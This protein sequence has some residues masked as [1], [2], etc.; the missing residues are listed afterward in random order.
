MAARP[1]VMVQDRDLLGKKVGRLRSQG[2]VPVN[3]VIPGDDSQALQTDERDLVGVLKET[4]QSGL[5]ELNSR[6]ATEVALIGD[7]QVHPVTRRVL[8][9]A[10]R[11]IDLT[12]PIQVAVPIDYVGVSP[13]SAASDR[14]VAHEL[15][16]LE[17]RCLPDDLPRSIEVDVSGLDQAGDVVRIASVASPEGVEILNDPDEVVVRVE[18]ERAEE[19]ETEAEDEFGLVG[20][21][22]E[23][24]D[25]AED[26]EAEA[27]PSD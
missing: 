10:F 26:G 16:A 17:V 8:H 11:R 9:V 4:G 14:F 3:L 24:G 15:Q 21:I 18:F 27:T 1:A 2:I 12:K 22:G 19:E 5:V 7:V 6:D 20:G 13:A 23:I 25:T